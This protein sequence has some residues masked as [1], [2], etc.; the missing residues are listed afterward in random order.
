MLVLSLRLEH[1][2]NGYN[3]QLDD[4]EEEDVRGVAAEGQFENADMEGEED[5]EEKN[6]WKISE[7]IES[8]AIPQKI[9]IQEQ[10]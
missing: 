2:D 3:D 8:S 5:D 10:D 1:N 9:K 7:S 4:A 6:E